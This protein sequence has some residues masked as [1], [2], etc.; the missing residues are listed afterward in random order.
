MKT[1]EKGG[2]DEKAINELASV[3]PETYIVGD[4]NQIGTI[5]T[6]NTEAFNVAVAI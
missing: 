4:T 5:A 2:E 3:I 1:I 6:A